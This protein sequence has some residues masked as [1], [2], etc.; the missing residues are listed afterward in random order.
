LI[1]ITI[2]KKCFLLSKD[3]VKTLPVLRS[4][5]GQYSVRS[6][7]SRKRPIRL[8]CVGAAK[9]LSIAE[10]VSDKELS[11][12]LDLYVATRNR[13]FFQYLQKA[14]I[15][16]PQ[17]ELW[18]QSSGQDAPNDRYCGTGSLPFPSLSPDKHV[19]HGLWCKGCELVSREWSSNDPIPEHSAHLVLPGRRAENVVYRYPE[20]ARSRAELL[21]HIEECPGAKKLLQQAKLS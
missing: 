4:I 13:G 16:P 5:P 6:S 1:P 17:Q 15:T 2:A 12:Y 10:H 7:I 19:E 3:A 14:S 11:A 8:V 9:K 20:I 18:L 21:A